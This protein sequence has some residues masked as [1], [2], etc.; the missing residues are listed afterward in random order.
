[1]APSSAD[2]AAILE[3]AERLRLQG[4]DP[5]SYSL[6]GGMPDEATVLDELPG[7]TWSVYYSERGQRRNE[8]TFNYLDTAL[9]EVARDLGVW[10]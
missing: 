6:E 1:V 10:L 2:E 9:E 3:V 8:R 4:V 7:G 5:D